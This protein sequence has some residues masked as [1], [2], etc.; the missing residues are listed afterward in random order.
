MKPFYGKWKYSKK[1]GWV[2]KWKKRK[3]KKHETIEEK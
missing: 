1:K 3:A 2:W